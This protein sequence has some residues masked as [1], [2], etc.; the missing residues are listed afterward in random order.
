MSKKTL[1]PC[2]LAMFVTAPVATLAAEPIEVGNRKQLFF[3]DVLIETLRNVELTMNPPFAT[4]EVLITA[5]QPH[6]RNSHISLYNSVL[7]EPDGRVRVW[8]DLLTITGS[9][10]YDHE[11]RVCYAESPDGIHFTKPALG[12]YAMEGSKETNVVLPGVIAGSAVWIDPQAPA[13]HRY[14]TQAKVY[15]SQKFHMHSSPDGIKWTLF[16][17]I[18]SRGAHDT[19]TIIFW[20]RH[21]ERYLFYGR[22]REVTPEIDIRCRS[23]R[24]AE[25]LELTRVENTG[26]VI[27]P[28][29]VDRATYDAPEGTTPVD[30]YG[31]TVFPY[32]EADDVYIMLAQAFWHWIPTD[33]DTRTLP[34]GT[35]DVR[36]AIS[37][38]SKH[39]RRVGKR[40]PFLRPGPAGRFDSR[41]I[42]AMPNPII[43]GDEIWIYY[44][45]LNW[46]RTDQT[47]PAAPH[48]RRM[49]AIS[50]A[51]MRLDGFVSADAPYGGGELTTRPLRFS[52]SRLELNVDTAGG[53][54]VRVEL[55]D[56]TGKPIRGLSGAASVW[57]VGNSVRLS[58]TWPG[59]VDLE[60]WAGK[61]V[62]LRFVLRDAK[63][64]AFQFRT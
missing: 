27:W 42:W 21:L 10:P 62:R 58:V 35:R 61:P 5:D 14:K 30:Y 7:K 17:E 56:G 20:D 13:E 18:N 12:L 44:S 52:G 1:A 16:A 19:Q 28:D 4:S 57:H 32:P 47:D 36:L 49:S 54:G 8:Y 45:G 23:V 53:G 51:V 9:G 11:R 38:D 26:L 55:L 43:V 46:D 34:P 60:S 48:G 39:F 31:A 33:R 40:G 37:R 22:N 63:L 3:D 41:Q 64:Y 24:R 6:E 2:L 50:R 59:D 25:L 15:P 29:A